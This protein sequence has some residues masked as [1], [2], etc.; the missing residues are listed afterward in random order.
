MIV[1]DE[2]INANEISIYKVVSDFA[3]IKSVFNGEE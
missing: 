2:D 3:G 1:V